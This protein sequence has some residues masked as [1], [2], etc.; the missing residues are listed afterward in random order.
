MRR[1]K[2]RIRTHLLRLRLLLA[3]SPKKVCGPVQKGIG[4]LLI[5]IL[6]YSIYIDSH[7][8]FSENCSAIFRVLISIFNVK[9]C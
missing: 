7:D 2:D 1:P 4:P 9:A 6:K 3:K 8:F 5:G